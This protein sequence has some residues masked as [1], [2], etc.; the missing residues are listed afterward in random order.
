MAV[1]GLHHATEPFAYS[2]LP[3]GEA[4]TGLGAVEALVRPHATHSYDKQER[5]NE[6]LQIQPRSHTII[7]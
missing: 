2:K 4:T 6:S 3:E 1:G 7:S 5:R